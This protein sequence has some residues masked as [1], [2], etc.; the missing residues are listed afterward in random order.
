MGVKKLWYKDRRGNRVQT[1]N[2]YAEWTGADG[3]SRRK[4]V[5]RDKR[6]AEAYL[7]RMQDAVAREKVGLGAAPTDAARTRPLDAWKA[8]YLAAL[9][10]GDVTARYVDHT[11]SQLDAA[12]AWCGW[13]VWADVTAASF[14]RYLA[15]RRAAHGNSNGTLNNHL[16]TAKTFARWV[17]DKLDARNPL[18]PLKPFNVETDRRRSKRVPT[19]AELAALIRAAVECP[20]AGRRLIT[21]PDRG[22]LYRVAAFTGFRASELASLTPESFALDATPPTVTVLAKDAKGRREEAIPLGAAVVAAIRPWLAGKAA[23][24]PLWPGTWARQRAQYG[25]FERDIPRAGIA[26][27][28]E[29]GRNLTFHS[30]RRYFVVRVI[31]AGGK[32]HE[33]RRMARHRSVQTTLNYYTDET[34]SELAELADRLPAV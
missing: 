25:W 10:T 3:R 23:G 14:A 11:S 7:V 18:R 30:L 15:H 24:Q 28:D 22:M 26:A 31:R 32:V 16:N 2:W 5:G 6:A 1:K 34:M 27:R 13:L 29:R 19:D 4:K 12:F 9:R 33:V 17:A 8:D 21:G 20:P